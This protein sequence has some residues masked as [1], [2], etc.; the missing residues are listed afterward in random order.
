MKKILLTGSNGFVGLHLIRELLKN[1]YSVVG[2]GITENNFIESSAFEYLKLDLSKANDVKLIDFSDIESVIH[3]AGLAAVGTSFDNPSEYINVNMGIEINLFETAL[4]QKCFPKFLI[5]SSGSLYDSSKSMPITEKSLIHPNSP[6]SVSKLGQENLAN[7]YS[8]RGFNC[9]IARPFNHIGPGQGLGFV[10]SD[11]ANQV[12]RIK[13]KQL[14]KISAGNLKTKRDYT[15]V[16]DIVRAYR[17]L[18]E[19]GKPGE[20]Y[21]ICSG[22]SIS[23]ETLLNKMFEISDIQPETTVDK[24]KIRLTDIE[25]IYGSYTKLNKDTGWSPEISLDQTI[26][27]ILADWSSKT[28]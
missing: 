12:I 24:T 11:I 23:G 15:D 25:D 13:N 4:K 10:A 21:N 19:K 8:S 3:L 28:A 1:N 16:R 22:T 17:L 18:L 2:C 9:I 14:D 20:I 26:S 7:Y 5:I 27:D 6:Y